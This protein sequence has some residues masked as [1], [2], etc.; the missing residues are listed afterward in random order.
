[1]NNPMTGYCWGGPKHGQFVAWDGRELRIQVAGGIRPVG[2]VSP[3]AKWGWLKRTI[4][5]ITGIWKDVTD[6]ENRQPYYQSVSEYT[7]RPHRFSDGWRTFLIWEGS[8]CMPTNEDA[9]M[10]MQRY[11]EHVTRRNPAPQEAYTF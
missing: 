1:M 2:P 6:Y 3:R 11:P 7:Y 8:D 4:A 9:L 10:L 5:K